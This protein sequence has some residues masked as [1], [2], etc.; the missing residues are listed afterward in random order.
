LASEWKEAENAPLPDEE[1]EDFKWFCNYCFC[2]IH[3]L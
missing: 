2:S 1:D 3:F